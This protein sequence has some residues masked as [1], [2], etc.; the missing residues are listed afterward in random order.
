MKQ[1]TKKMADLPIFSE[2]SLKPEVEV[3]NND[4]H[5]LLEKNITLSEEI[6]AKV[7][8]L[9]GDIKKRKVSGWIKFLLFIVLP[10][11]ISYIYLPPLINQMMG[12]LK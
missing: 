5:A 9:K 6:L 12:L 8:Y 7:D 2:K 4:L 10:L 1:D 11:I 3:E